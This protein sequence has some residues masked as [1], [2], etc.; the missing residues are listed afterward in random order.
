MRDSGDVL[1]WIDFKEYAHGFN[2]TLKQEGFGIP[3]G[4]QT[5]A[6]CVDCEYRKSDKHIYTWSYTL[7]F[8]DEQSARKFEKYVKKYL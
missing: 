5:L 1:Q 3:S 2:A 7:N 4:G 6:I 8:S